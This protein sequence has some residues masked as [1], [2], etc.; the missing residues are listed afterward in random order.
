MAHAEAFFGGFDF[1]VNVAAE[2]RRSVTALG[3]RAALLQLFQDCRV[4]MAVTII[5]AAAAAGAFGSRLGRS[6]LLRH[7]LSPAPAS[8][9]RS[10]KPRCK[11]HHPFPLVRS[12]QNRVKIPPR[13]ATTHDYDFI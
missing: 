1:G 8:N 12:L 13:T 2:Q 11:P 5:V 4:K 10:S 7:I 3:A 9:N 6:Q